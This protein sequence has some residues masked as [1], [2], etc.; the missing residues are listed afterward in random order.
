MINSKRIVL[1]TFDSLGDL[2]PAMALAL[3]LQTR[4]HHVVIATTEAY[5]SKSLNKETQTV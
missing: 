2:H 1:S 3:E 4:G 5:R